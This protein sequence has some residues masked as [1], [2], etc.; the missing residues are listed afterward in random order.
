MNKDVFAK[1]MGLTAAAFGKEISPLITES[2]WEIFAGWSDEKFTDVMRYLRSASDLKRFP[3]AP[4]ITA[5]AGGGPDKQAARAWNVVSNTS[6]GPAL[7]DFEDKLINASIR[8]TGGKEYYGNISAHEFETWL[9]PRFLDAYKGFLASPPDDRLTC[10]LGSVDGGNE[11]MLEKL[12]M[13]TRTAFV[14]CDYLPKTEK[15]I[16]HK[17]KHSNESKELVNQF[18]I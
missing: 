3:T 1:Q 6:F 12:G 2:Y 11:L 17:A 9:R 10:K 7:I 4:E 13:P 16:E 8:Q 18:K 15:R 14:R 5:A